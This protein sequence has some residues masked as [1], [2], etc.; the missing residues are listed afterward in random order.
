MNLVQRIVHER[1]EKHEKQ[2]LSRLEQAWMVFPVYN[3]SAA[4][5]ALRQ[6]RCGSARFFVSFVL[7]VLFVDKY[8]KL[9]VVRGEYKFQQ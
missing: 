3:K 6:D 9:H 5:H 8:L 7:F 2:T 4:R 1:H